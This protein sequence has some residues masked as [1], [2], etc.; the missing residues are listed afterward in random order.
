ML[1]CVAEL[2]DRFASIR[3]DL[4][5]AQKMIAQLNETC[6][7]LAQEKMML[8]Q[9]PIHLGNK[10]ELYEKTAN[11]IISTK[12]EIISS[13]KEIVEEIYLEVF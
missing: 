5:V 11:D 1:N 7:N 8:E 9:H 3:E 12:D 10:I 6:T 13:Y 4:G 2:N